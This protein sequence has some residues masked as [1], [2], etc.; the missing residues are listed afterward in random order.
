MEKLT[1]ENFLLYIPYGLGIGNKTLKGDLASVYIMEIENKNDKGIMNV[2]EGANQ[3]PLLYPL[4]A[5]NKEFPHISYTK[6][7]EPSLKNIIPNEFFKKHWF[8]EIREDGH[9]ST[10]NGDGSATGYKW[11]S[12]RIDIILLLAE[13]KIDYM[14]L[15]KKGLAI[16]VNTLKTNPYEIID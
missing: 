3:I 2:L 12:C 1:L 11:R 10:D 7:L 15:I 13:W 5:L 4:S 9:F 14:G 6:E 8:T 16:D